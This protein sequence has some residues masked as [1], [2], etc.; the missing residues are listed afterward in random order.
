MITKRGDF[1]QPW[2]VARTGLPAEIRRFTDSTTAPTQRRTADQITRG[3][4]SFLD[5]CSTPL[6]E[7]VRRGDPAASGPAVTAWGKRRVDAL[8]ARFDAYTAGERAQLARAR[9]PPAPTRSGR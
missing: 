2:Q 5:D 4:R 1:L 6:V 3:V 8:R 7:T 9:T